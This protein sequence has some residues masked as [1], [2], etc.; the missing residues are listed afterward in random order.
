MSP[1]AKKSSDSFPLLTDCDNKWGLI[2]NEGN[3]S[4]DRLCGAW[5][6]LYQGLIQF[7]SALQ[8]RGGVQRE[9]EQ[10]RS[11]MFAVEQ[12]IHQIDGSTPRK[13]TATKVPQGEFTQPK[14]KIWFIKEPKF[15][16]NEHVLFVWC[17]F[18]VKRWTSF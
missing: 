13:A 7:Q 17:K 16:L 9:A 5:K 11:L 18:P 2:S 4:L 12:I 6:L 8:H 14:N 10:L 1:C 15:L 3:V